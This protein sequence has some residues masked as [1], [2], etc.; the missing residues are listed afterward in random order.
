MQVIR[1][2]AWVLGF[3]MA[4]PPRDSHGQ[5]GLTSTAVDTTTCV[6]N[7]FKVIH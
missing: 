6:Q 1:G 3:L 2:V 5:L 7:I 4:P